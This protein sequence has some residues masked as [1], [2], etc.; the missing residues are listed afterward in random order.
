MQTALLVTVLITLIALAASANPT[1]LTS[2]I[3]SNTS[4]ITSL[5]LNI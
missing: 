5:A 4:R 1:T 2:L 3:A